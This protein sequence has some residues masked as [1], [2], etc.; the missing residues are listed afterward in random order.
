MMVCA[1][2]YRVILTEWIK[3]DLHKYLESGRYPSHSFPCIIF[4]IVWFALFGYGRF[5]EMT[6]ITKETRE[7]NICETGNYL[8]EW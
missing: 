6:G 3:P 4:F 8:I 5:K 1:P 7:R 2:F